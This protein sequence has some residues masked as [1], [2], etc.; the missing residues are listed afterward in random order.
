MEPKLLFLDKDTFQPKNGTQ[1]SVLILRKKTLKEIDSQKN[2]KPVFAA[3]VKKIGH[4]K[5]GNT[6]FKRD[7]EGNEVLKEK[8]ETIKKDSN[9]KIFESEILVK[10]KVI[11]DETDEIADLFNDWKKE[12]KTKFPEFNF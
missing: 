11:D 7:N 2:L 6:I 1:T 10:E 9:N 4:D 5:R 12:K 8:K 3:I